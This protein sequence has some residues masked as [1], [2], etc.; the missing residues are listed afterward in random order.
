M[1]NGLGDN[2]K[3]KLYIK[4]IELR[5]GL[6]GNEYTETK[7][8]AKELNT[9]VVKIN[10][11]LWAIQEQIKRRLEKGQIKQETIKR[12]AHHVQ[13]F[14]CGKIKYKV[15]ILYITWRNML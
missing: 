10:S 9:T 14:L 4:I 8:I 5:Y 7:D 6:N 15:I 13:T 1:S 2:M 3:Q 11:R 12:S